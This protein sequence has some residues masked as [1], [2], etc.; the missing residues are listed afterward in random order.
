MV[1]FVR[2]MSAR[3]L[4]LQQE[5]RG[6]RGT[7]G[8]EDFAE[9]KSRLKKVEQNFRV[10]STSQTVP[11]VFGRFKAFADTYLKDLD[12]AK[13]LLSVIFEDF[14]VDKDLKK[15]H[16]ELKTWVVDKLA[17]LDTTIKQSMEVCEQ[18][19][20]LK[21]SG[22]VESKL[23][24]DCE[25]LKLALWCLENQASAMTQSSLQHMVAGYF[26][27]MNLVKETHNQLQIPGVIGHGKT[28][29]RA[30]RGHVYS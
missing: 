8:T 7:F 1:T 28:Y 19:H 2:A 29:V 13:M 11:A 5:L 22:S 23:N 18:Y 26:D 9:F 15:E 10:I 21:G 3:I 17:C 12:S 14:C 24:Y 27:I 16:D 20:L 6:H 25:D 4:K 30:V